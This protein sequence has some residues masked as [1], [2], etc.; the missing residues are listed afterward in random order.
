MALNYF[1]SKTWRECCDES[2]K[3]CSIITTPYC[4]RTIED[5]WALFRVKNAFP[6]PCGMEATMKPASSKLPP[7]LRDNEDLRKKIV[8][9]CTQNVMDLKM[10]N[11][12]EYIIITLLPAVLE[13][14]ID[15]DADNHQ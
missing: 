15:C 10:H 7:I 2:S 4:G 8:R 11:A 13:L 9:Y 3:I 1:P 14:T 12:R 5:W 6:H